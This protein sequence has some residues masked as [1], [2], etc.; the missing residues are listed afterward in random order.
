MKKCLPAVLF[1]L[2]FIIFE[3]A[4]ADDL[5]FSR[6]RS[7]IN[8]IIK[9]KI[10]K[11]LALEL[12]D[13]YEKDAGTDAGQ[14]NWSHIRRLLDSVT[15]NVTELKKNR[16]DIDVLFPGILASDIGKTRVGDIIKESNESGLVFPGLEKVKLGD[17]DKFKAFLLHE[18][19][20]I[21]FVTK[22][23]RELGEQAHLGKK[24]IDEM[25]D[26]S[27]QVSRYHCGPSIQGTW[28][29]V[30]F[31]KMFSIPYGEVTSREG[32]FHALVDRHDQSSLILQD[33][34]LEGGTVKIL[35]ETWRNNNWN[36]DKKKVSFAEF[37]RNA[38]LENSKNTHR[39]V[40]A[41]LDL[42]KKD[43]K[44]SGLYKMKV[45]KQKAYE[46]RHV[47]E[48]VKQYILFRV[49]VVEGKKEEDVIVRLPS[50]NE[51]S[52]N[53][54]DEFYSKIAK[55]LEE[56]RKSKKHPALH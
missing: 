56:E 43:K 24:K 1:F 26:R 39:Q 23:L 19:W 2:C 6:I 30:N 54:P 46:A 25:I 5:G 12:V 32:W 37:V 44:F 27:V 47:I 34:R 35:N 42:S 38:F 21:K 36:S 55:A 31:E 18:E 45:S 40:K 7:D 15:E 52:V 48:Q 17:K 51:F 11:K 20:G 28:W 41:L 49:K 53:N 22:R 3:R 14:D 16:I 8:R 10:Y 29:Q 13:T 50:G 9:D 4:N 33:G